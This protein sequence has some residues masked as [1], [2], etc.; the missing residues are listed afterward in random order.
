[1]AEPE[2]LI[3]GSAS[4]GPKGQVVIPV[5]FRNQ[6][7]I[8]PGDTVIFMGNPKQTAFA[9]MNPD[10]LAEIQAQLG[11]IKNKMSEINK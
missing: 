6:Y 8:K 3:Y 7:N 1:M 9:V 5:K 4:V 11:S 2:E 10:Q